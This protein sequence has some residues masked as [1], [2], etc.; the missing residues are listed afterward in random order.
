MRM[1][2][3][4]AA[5]I[6]LAG[7]ARASDPVYARVQ[8]A[9]AQA[10]LSNGKQFTTAQGDCYPFL[11]YDGP[12]TMMHLQFG[13]QTFWLQKEDAAVVPAT[14]T[15]NAAAQYN[16]EIAKFEAIASVPVPAPGLDK[17]SIDAIVQ[18]LSGPLREMIR[19]ELADG[20][21]EKPAEVR[22]GF[23]VD[24]VS[25]AWQNS[26]VRVKAG[27][28]V[29]VEA[30]DGDTW[31]IGAGWGPIDAKGYPVSHDPNADLP[32]YHTGVPN[33][34]WHYG[35][36][37][38][39][40]G[41][42]GDELNDPRYQIEIGTRKGFTTDTEGYVYFMCNDRAFSDNTGIIHVKVTVSDAKPNPVL[43]SDDAAGYVSPDTDATP[44]VHSMNA[45]GMRADTATSSAPTVSADATV[46][47]Q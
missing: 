35:S 13:P 2:W 38:C 24:A 8:A 20:A 1:T 47:A 32:I 40:V 46:P 30:K 23:P 39:A 3:F 16:N 10:T 33:V 7:I 27:Q 26:G 37:I 34:D 17:Q 28:H 43:K 29:L 15:S 44:P 18:E 36:L 11:G 21:G 9:S 22:D 42:R 45:P 5:F 31:D 19:Q 14:N 6:L 25:D 41:D 12:Q 4:A